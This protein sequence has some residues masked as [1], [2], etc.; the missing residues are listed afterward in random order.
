MEIKR[1]VFSRFERENMGISFL[2]NQDAA[3]RSQ[4]PGSC[5]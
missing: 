2:E 1:I 3:K 4:I 5:V